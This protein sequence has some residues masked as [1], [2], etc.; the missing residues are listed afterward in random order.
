LGESSFHRSTGRNGILSLWD[1][2]AHFVLEISDK[3]SDNGTHLKSAILH[4]NSN[5][6][7][8]AN[9]PQSSQPMVQSLRCI[10]SILPNAFSGL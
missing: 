5:F 8:P 9:R 4:V 2:A 1:H 3:R 10:G 7:N 6:G